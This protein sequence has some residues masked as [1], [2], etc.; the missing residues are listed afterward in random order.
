MILDLRKDYLSQK[1]GTLKQ[2]HD[3]FLSKGPLPVPLVRK[4]LLQE[5]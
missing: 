1:G 3:A 4:L 2:F 5:R